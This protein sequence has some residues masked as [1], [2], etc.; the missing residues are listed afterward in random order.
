MTPG[1]TDAADWSCQSDSET[2]QS[3]QCIANAPL[4][5]ST[6]STFTITTDPLPA[7]TDG[8]VVVADATV[9][10]P[11]GVTDSNA[12]NNTNS[13]SVQVG[14]PV[15]PVFV[16]GEG[17]LRVNGSSGPDEVVISRGSGGS[18]NVRF[19]GANYN[20]SPTTGRFL[21]DLGDGA[22][23]LVVSGNLDE[24]HS[25]VTSGNGD[26]YLATGAGDDSIVIAGGRNIVLPGR[27]HDAVTSGSG[28][29][30]VDG[31]SGSDVIHSGAGN[32]EV[33]GGDGDDTIFGGDG[34]D[35]LSGGAGNDIVMG[36]TGNDILSGYAGNDVLVGGDNAD[37]LFGRSGDDVLVGGAG[38]DGLHGEDGADLLIGG[39]T[40]VDANAELLADARLAWLSNTAAI[41][42][43]LGQ[44]AD[45]GVAD[46]LN[47]GVGPDIFVGE[48]EHD[49]FYRLTGEDSS[50]FL[51]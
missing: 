49:N 21:I 39:R 28:D 32:D 23:S 15:L 16:D 48:P 13:D 37:R 46:G 4:P 6:S 29:D 27:G 31:G 47:G 8:Q 11:S 41:P 20:E 50:L 51:P 10:S 18:I 26:D 9:T 38:G 3:I 42:T 19:N 5:A 40:D 25:E 36:G 30:D 2:P 33:L 17:N 1:G 44:L 7:S 35:L 22:N 34:N 14:T 12:S 43:E 45:E 24:Y